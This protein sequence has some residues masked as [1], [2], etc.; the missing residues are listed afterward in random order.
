MLSTEY[1]KKKEMF[2]GY[3]EVL[4]QLHDPTIAATGLTTAIEVILQAQRTAMIAATGS[5]VA[6]ANASSSSSS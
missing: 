1:E 3:Y 5:A 6:A 4:Q 2:L